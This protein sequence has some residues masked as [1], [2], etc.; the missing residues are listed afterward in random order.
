MELALRMPEP[1][2]GRPDPQP[3]AHSVP[4]GWSQSAVRLCIAHVSLPGLGVLA[5]REPPVRPEDGADA[6]QRPGAGTGT[7]T[8]RA[9][10]S[11]TV[12]RAA[13]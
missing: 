4:G 2:A 7:L 1:T 9:Q 13:A 8:D 3:A 11:S 6:K 10:A 5:A 12:S